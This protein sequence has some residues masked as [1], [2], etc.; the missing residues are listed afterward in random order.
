MEVAWSPD[1]RMLAYLRLRE[2]GKRFNP[3]DMEGDLYVVPATGGESKRIT[4]SP[5][6]EMWVSW[7][8]DGKWLTFMIEGEAW[9]ASI[10]GGEPKK[11]QRNYIPSSW[12][13]D[14][15]SYLA[16]GPHGELQRVY[17][18]ETASSELPARVPPDARPIS[19]SPNGETILYR[20]ITSGTQC[21]SIDV[22]HLVNQ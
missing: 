1:G 7:T 16:F 3:E 13:S 9:V 6:K 5:E 11:L 4:N 10:D 21:W 8:P 17:L 18:N 22:S 2:K 14:G 12:S 19:M 20:Q 15:T